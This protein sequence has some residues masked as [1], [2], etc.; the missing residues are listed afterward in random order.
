MQGLFD[1]HCLPWA[2]GF[3]PLLFLL[4]WHEADCE[5]VARRALRSAKTRSQT[6]NN[7]IKNLK[8]C[9]MILGFSML[10]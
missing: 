10:Q 2:G 1:F 5:A 9:I 3:V 8:H 6:W 4:S 7:T